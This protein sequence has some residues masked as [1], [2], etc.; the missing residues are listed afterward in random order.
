MILPGFTSKKI[1]KCWQLPLD[2]LPQK[3]SIWPDD[4]IHAWSTPSHLVNTTISVRSLCPNIISSVE[5]SKH[6][7]I[8]GWM[9]ANHL[10]RPNRHSKQAT[11]NQPTHPP[12]P[13]LNRLNPNPTPIRPPPLLPPR[14][15]QSI[16]IKLTISLQ[17]IPPNRQHPLSA[18]A[19][20]GPSQRLP[21]PP[22]LK[23]M[24]EKK[25][26]L[27]AKEPSHPP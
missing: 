6:L 22:T 9:P 2:D 26:A 3:D 5:K 21:P 17:P 8:V 11:S 15:S 14:R 25:C 23:R 19:R 24:M 18:T 13:R 20:Q 7:E 16:V 1:G 27:Q 12:R 10:S 4:V